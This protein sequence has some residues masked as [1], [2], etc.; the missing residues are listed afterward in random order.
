MTDDTPNPDGA[1]LDGAA[2]AAGIILDRMLGAMTSERGVHVESLFTALGAH[3][4]HACQ[5]AALDGL[6]TE[7]PDY[8]GLSYIEVK[9]ANGDEYLFGDAINRPLAESQHSFWQLIGAKISQLGGEVPDATEYFRH[10]AATVGSDQF[11]LPRYAEG[12]AAG[13]TPRGYLPSFEALRPSIVVSAPDPQQWPVAYGI[14]VR[15]ALDM[16]GGQFDYGVLARIVM[17][18]AI[19]TSKLR[20]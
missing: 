8:A 9:G 7:H 10:S 16:T 1:F 4:G 17:D 12:T 11:G 18:S 2:E 13:D 3:A 5:L 20:V 14:A 19:A 15:S 6:A